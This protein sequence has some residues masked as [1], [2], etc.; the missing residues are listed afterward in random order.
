MGQVSIGAWVSF[1]VAL[2]LSPHL[3]RDC[4]ATSIAIDTPRHVRDSQ[5]VLGHSSLATTEI[6]YNQA[7][8]LSA[9][10]AWQDT[11]AEL[12]ARGHVGR[13]SLPAEDMAR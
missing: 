5:H 12:P 11:L 1:A 7:K 9:A 13:E 3:F 2:T 6:H 10:R 4:A 8:C